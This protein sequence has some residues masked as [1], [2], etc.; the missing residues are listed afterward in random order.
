MDIIAKVRGILLSPPEPVLVE[1]VD[2]RKSRR[3]K[4]REEE[5]NKKKADKKRWKQ[6]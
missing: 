4:R 3:A 6:G 1:L 2:G 5:R